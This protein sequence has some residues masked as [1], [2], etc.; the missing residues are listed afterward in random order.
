M[1]AILFATRYCYCSYL[2]GLAVDRRNGQIDD[3]VV[4]V[5]DVAAAV[6]VVVVVVPAF[7]DA[8]MAAAACTERAEEPV[9]CPHIHCAHI[10]TT[11]KHE[12]EQVA[13]DAMVAVDASDYS[14]CDNT[15]AA[16]QTVEL[17]HL[18]SRF[19]RTR[20]GR[21]AWRRFFVV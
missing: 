7:D 21:C 13:A 19:F 14:R 18:P 9:L 6:V 12:D 5:V 8:V 17:A 3:V 11:G 16:N 4:V 10:H 2:L 1:R 15:V 20:L